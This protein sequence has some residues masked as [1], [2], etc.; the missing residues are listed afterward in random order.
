MQEDA[1]E[2]VPAVDVRTNCPLLDIPIGPAD[3]EPLSLN[4][5]LPLIG[6]NCSLELATF[7]HSVTRSSVD[8]PCVKVSF[9]K[10]DQ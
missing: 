7:V 1:R 6:G 3:I 2:D 8:V 10:I 5:K 9:D 4:V